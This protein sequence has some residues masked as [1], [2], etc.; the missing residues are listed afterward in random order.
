M[1]GYV[2]SLMCLYILLQKVFHGFTWVKSHY[3]IDYLM[4]N[5]IS[6]IASFGVT[7]TLKKTCGVIDIWWIHIKKKTYCL[8]THLYIH[9][10]SIMNITAVVRTPVR[11]PNRN[12][13]FTYETYTTVAPM[14][15]SRAPMFCSQED[16][17]TRVTV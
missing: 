7:L 6:M 12:V 4:Y 2:C 9:I 15:R 8:F 13:F 14:S 17:N 3:E 11:T 16:A 5:I 10:F 1:F